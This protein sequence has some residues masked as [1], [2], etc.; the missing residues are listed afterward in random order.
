MLTKLLVAISLAVL[1]P[2][3][4]FSQSLDSYEPPLVVC[5][6]GEHSGHH[7]TP[8]APEILDRIASRT[9]DNP[10]VNIVVTYN[11]FPPEAQNAFQAA[12][13]I[14]AYSISSP[15][16]IRITANWTF[17]SSGMLGS[18]G[19]TYVYRNFSNAPD[20]KFYGS[21]LADKI[22][23]Y[24]LAPSQ[25]DI[26]ANFNS[27]QNW[28][29]GTDGNGT[30]SQYDFMSVVLHELG[31]G[32]GFASSAS[33]I[34]GIGEFGVGT[35]DIPMV[36]DKFMTQGLNGPTL[37]SLTEGLGLGAIFIGN[38]V[39]CNGEYA[40]IANDGVKPRFM[41]RPFSVIVR[42]YLTSMSLL[43]WQDRKIA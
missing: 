19:S 11:N 26:T 1:S 14:W 10:C 35:V 2:V 9:A 23:G 4:A 7:Y 31:H 24:D 38:N 30:W 22:A 39:Y 28:Y 32:L 37:L 25:P 21:A 16:T 3:F 34:A 41:L 8:V 43:I 17:M 12:I 18:A 36:Y 40:G 27:T 42:P 13:D 5:P 33:L 15:V 6:A 29:Y 20:D